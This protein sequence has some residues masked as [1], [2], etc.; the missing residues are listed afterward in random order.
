MINMKTVCDDGYKEV[1][2]GELK[3]APKEAFF[4]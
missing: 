2:G 4:I 3:N 1:K